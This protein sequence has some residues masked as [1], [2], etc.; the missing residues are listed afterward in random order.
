MCQEEKAYYG[1]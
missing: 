1:C